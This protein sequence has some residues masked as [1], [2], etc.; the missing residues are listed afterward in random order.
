MD[1]CSFPMTPPLVM[2]MIC[3]AAPSSRRHLRHLYAS[4]SAPRLANKGLGGVVPQRVQRARVSRLASRAL[5]QKVITVLKWFYYIIE[6][7]GNRASGGVKST[8]DS[9]VCYIYA[10]YR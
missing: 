4:V 1:C 7:S 6:V 2:M 3:K 8:F 10:T 5:T 9:N